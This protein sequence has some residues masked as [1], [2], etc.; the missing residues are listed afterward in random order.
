MRCAV[1]QFSFEQLGAEVA[2][3]GAFV[4]NA[5]SAAVSRAIGYRENGRSRDAPRGVPQERIN[6]ALTREEWLARRDSLPRATVVG[7]EAASR[8]FGLDG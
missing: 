8:M 5:A 3:S 1:L 4:D 7:F 2:R 6:F